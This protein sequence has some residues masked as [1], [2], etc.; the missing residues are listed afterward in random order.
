MADEHRLRIAFSVRGID[1]VLDISLARNSDPGSL[2]YPLLSGGQPV[3]FARGF[4]VCRASVT[5]PADGYA[6]I[7]GWTQMVRSTDSGRSDFEMDPISIYRDIPTPYAWYGLKP[8]LFDAPSRETRYDMDWE[9][10]SFFCLSPDAVM[11]RHVQAITGFSWGFTVVGTGI[12]LVRPAV[13]GSEVWN[14]HLDLLRAS[15]SEWAF[16][17]GYARG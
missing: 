12:T 2:G 8:D 16:D 7:F 13:L 6:A 17:A 4:P 1:G 14:G 10:H 11:T 3:E 15:Y 9:A 5:Y